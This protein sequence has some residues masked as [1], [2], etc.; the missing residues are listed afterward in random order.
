MQIS[1]GQSSLARR[2]GRATVLRQR[3]LALLAALALPCA[4]TAQN[5]QF[6]PNSNVVAGVT[7]GNTF[8]TYTG[9]GGPATA[10]TFPGAPLDAVAD[11][12]GNIY[13]ADTTANAIRRVDAVTGIIT[14]VAG[15]GAS[16]STGDG[17]PATNASVAAP[18]S[19]AGMSESGPE[20][21]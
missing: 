3:A 11:A 2:S 14:T 19:V 7:L 10:A 13:I 4:A 15:N 18:A 1:S 21:L 12:F 6:L 20:C 16:S 5:V 8:T 9:E 17:G